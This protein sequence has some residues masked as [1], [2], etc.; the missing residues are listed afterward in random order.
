MGIS[1]PPWGD[2]LTFISAAFKGVY[3]EPDLSGINTELKTTIKG[4]SR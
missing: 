2:K 1:K 3:V 4:F